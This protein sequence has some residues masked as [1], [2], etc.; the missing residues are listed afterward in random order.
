MMTRA[1][2][3]ASVREQNGAETACS[4]ATTVTPVSG[5]DDSDMLAAVISR[6]SVR[7]SQGHTRPSHSFAPASRFNPII[8]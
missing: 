5:P 6:R 8:A 7:S 4:T 3:S 1:P 2:R